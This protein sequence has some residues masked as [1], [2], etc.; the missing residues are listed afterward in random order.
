MTAWPW[1]S[2]TGEQ[3]H[4]RVCQED[5]VQVLLVNPTLLVENFSELVWSIRTKSACSRPRVKALQTRP[6]SSSGRFWLCMYSFP[7]RR[8][9]S[10]A[11]AQA[12]IDGARRNFSR[13]DRNRAS[14]GSRPTGL[15]VSHLQMSGA[16][17][18]AGMRWH[19]PRTRS[20]NNPLVVRTGQL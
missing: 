15:H 8:R 18:P 19:Q 14:A 10:N 13:K 7:S 17:P 6:T 3:Y 2:G 12:A 1:P 5:V 20:A 4:H 11:R 9:G 16:R